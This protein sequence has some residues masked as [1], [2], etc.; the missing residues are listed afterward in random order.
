MNALEDAMEMSGGLPRAG[1]TEAWKK[2]KYDPWIG[3]DLDGTLAFYEHWLRWDHIG[4]PIAPMVSRV[5]DWLAAGKKVKIMTAR[6]KPFDSARIW[7]QVTG[8]EISNAMIKDNIKAWCKLHIGVE[9]EVTCIKDLNMI[10][11][12]DDRAVQVIPNTGQT[13]SDAHEAEVSALKG[14]VAWPSSDK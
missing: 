2:E 9:L 13:L 11:L 8:R 7:C 6:I 5:K 4:E 10:E 3:V 14:K 12:W 1:D